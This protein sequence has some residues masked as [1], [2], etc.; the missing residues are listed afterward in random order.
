VSHR[1]DEV[2]SVA[3]RV[4]V[5]R[6][7]KRVDTRAT[8]DYDEATLIRQ[9][10]GRSV[11]LQHGDLP[12]K[13]VA[14]GV[15]LLRVRGLIGRRL[16]GF[17]LDA[18]PGEV[19]GITGLTGSGRE[20]VAGLLFGTSKP[21]AGVIEIG[22]A[23][24]HRIDPARAKRLGVALVPS[25]RRRMAVLPD[26]SVREN[27]SVA[28]VGALRRGFLV[29]TRRERALAA[30]WIATLGVKPSRIEESILN[31]S[32]GNQQKVI[33]ARWLRRSPRVLILDEP[34]QGVDVGT[35]PEIYSLLR[36]VA[37]GGS[38]VIVC[39]TDSEEVVEVSTRA[40]VISR[41]RVHTELS[42]PTLTLD[43]LNHEIV[44]A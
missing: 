40:L 13:G 38:T 4:T 1:L 9:I 41:G 14:K 25:D 43:R 35:K 32:G 37:A 33:L 39:S 28:D 24:V 19:I 6:D 36:Q 8:T 7:G 44:A 18:Q 30:Q 23:T 11:D 15:P 42:G 22:G 21:R 2:F 5:M 12:H 3:D 26:A 29:Q 27:M 34:T 20:E 31:L 10:L 17:D 16:D